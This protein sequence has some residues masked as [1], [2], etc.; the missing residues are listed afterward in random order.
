MLIYKIYRIGFIDKKLRKFIYQRLKIQP[1]LTNLKLIQ[2]YDIR[3]AKFIAYTIYSI[4]TLRVLRSVLFIENII[5]VW[6]YYLLENLVNI[7]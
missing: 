3:A 1:C 7:L 6:F 2:R 4:A 5:K